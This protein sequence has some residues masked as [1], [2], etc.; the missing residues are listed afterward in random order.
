M[1]FEDHQIGPENVYQDRF[2]CAVITVMLNPS[3]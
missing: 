3:T 1:V 2:H